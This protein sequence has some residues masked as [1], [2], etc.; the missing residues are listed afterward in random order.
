M[1]SSLHASKW[2]L[3]F[4]VS[5]FYSRL[6]GTKVS[7]SPTP[8]FPIQVHQFG[9]PLKN[10]PSR[11][12]NYQSMVETIIVSWIISDCKLCFPNPRYLGELTQ[13]PKKGFSRPPRHWVF[14]SYSSLCVFPKNLSL[15]VSDLSPSVKRVH[16]SANPLKTLETVCVTIYH[17]F[18]PIGQ[19]ISD[20]E[21]IWVYNTYLFVPDAFLTLIGCRAHVAPVHSSDL[22]TW[23]E[24]YP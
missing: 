10:T 2:F 18:L 3:G 8:S 7:R 5:A 6:P 20:F 21:Q 17:S 11:V 24:T 19:A 22:E 12:L 1:L 16:Q 15:P 14:H 23:G 13:I 9:N 4:C